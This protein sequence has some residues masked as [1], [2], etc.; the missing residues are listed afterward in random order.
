MIKINGNRIEPAEIESAVKKVLG[1][2]WAAAKGFEADGSAF[3]CAYYTEAVAV[4]YDRVRAELQKHLPYYMLPSYFIKIDR[5][6]L[7]PNGKLDRKAL[8]PPVTE[9][10]RADYEAPQDEV[11]QEAVRRVRGRAQNGADR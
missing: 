5:V 11:E 2:G 4:D 1:I 9:R 3:I 10:Y 8:E 6:P 7:N